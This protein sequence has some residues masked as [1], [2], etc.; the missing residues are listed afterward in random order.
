M[1]ANDAAPTNREI[2]LSWK[3]SA[4]SGV[5]PATIASCTTQI[6][7][8]DQASRL[9]TAATPVLAHMRDELRST[10]HNVL[11]ADANCHLV[12][13]WFD[14]TRL[15]STLSSLGIRIGASLC[16]EAVGTNGLGT[17]IETRQSILLNGSDHFI[18]PF[19]QFS[20][21][22][23]PIINQVTQRLEGVLC[24]TGTQKMANPLLAP[25][26]ARA[27]SAIQSRLVDCSKASERTI[28]SA[29]QAASRRRRRPI[30]ALGE[31]LV[32][33]N[34]AA[35][36]LL[37]PDDY[38]AL[39]Q[40]IGDLGQAEAR[41]FLTLATGAQVRIRVTRIDGTADGALFIFNPQPV[42][43]MKPLDGTAIAVDSP[44]LIHGLAGTGKT[45]EAIRIAPDAAFVDC[46]DAVLD[47]MWEE[48]LRTGLAGSDPIVLEHLEQLP[49]ALV[50]PVLHT[51]MSQPRRRI[52]MTCGPVGDLPHPHAA[53]AA[54]VADQIHLEP[55]CLRTQEMPQIAARLIN[56]I[57]PH[58]DLRLVP[59]VIETL[60]SQP[61]PGNLHELR[62]VLG[63]VTRHRTTG[64]V[65]LSDLPPT[66]RTQ[67]AVRRLA[68]RE[69][70]ERA[71]IMA[72][73]NAAHGN[74]SRAAAD[75]GISRTTL[76]SRMRALKVH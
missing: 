61:W 17:V 7:E 49:D 33:T 68:G 60:A 18:N 47:E 19:K 74:K 71:A 42:A 36:D 12:Y 46:A 73:L 62:A 50:T 67:G 43:G 59:S 2:R 15:E 32:L 38:A 35:L 24:V 69:R 65:T 56:E 41:P 51:I 66:H 8:I 10:R 53:I 55:L 26:V 28:L 44:V 76:Y 52:V 27:A 5:S 6:A 16:E 75:L 39:R 54:L 30:A 48:Q 21:Y 13:Q 20:C 4:L 37:E 11:L 23:H 64:D 72:A 45:A 58:A 57:A 63:F 25:L 1:D 3:R 14:D 40:L 31:D 34:N 70:A 22:G 9:M 29:F